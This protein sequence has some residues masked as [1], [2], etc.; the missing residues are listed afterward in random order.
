MYVSVLVK[1]ED[2][3]EKVKRGKEIFKTGVK[4]KDFFTRKGIFANVKELEQ[5]DIKIAKKKTQNRAEYPPSTKVPRRK[6]AEKGIKWMD[7]VQ[8]AQKLADSFIK[9]I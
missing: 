8:A 7:E 4:R 3:E 2:G 5:K 9:D 1:T 6:S